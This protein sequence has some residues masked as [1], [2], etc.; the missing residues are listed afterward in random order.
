MALLLFVANR[1]LGALWQVGEVV[2]LQAEG[3]AHIFQALYS[4]CA[5]LLAQSSMFVSFICL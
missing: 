3:I 4:F 2:A 1:T 5:D